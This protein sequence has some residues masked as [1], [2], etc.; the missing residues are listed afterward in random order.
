MTSVFKNGLFSFLVFFVFSLPCAFAGDSPTPQHSPRFLVHLLDYLAK[1]YAGAVSPQ[2]KVLSKSEYAEQVEFVES[3]IST[4]NGLQETK[5]TP[6]IEKDLEQLKTLI[7]GKAQPDDV[8]KLARELQRKVIEVSELEIFPSH[9][10]DLKLGQS[11]YAQNCISCHGER[12]KGDGPA[13]QSLTP[14]PANF[15]DGPRMRE[16]SPFAAFNT[17]R[18]GVSGTAMAGFQGMSD[19]EVWALAFYISSL[20][21]DKKTPEN[22]TEFN[23]N[24]SEIL[25]GAASLSDPALLE[26]LPGSQDEKQKTLAT[27]RTF[28]P[29]EDQVSYL[30]LAR[31]RLNEAKVFFQQ[32][33]IES[34]KTK[35]LQAYLEGIEPIEPKVR[36]TDPS[37]VATIEEKMAAVRGAIESKKTP[38]ELDQAIKNAFGEMEKISK[39]IEHRDMSPLVAFFAAFAII[40]REGFEAVLIILAL[41]GV[42]RAAGAKQAALWVHGG[43]ISAIGCGFIAWM[44]SGWIMGISGASR[45]MM[46]GATSLFAVIVLLYVGFWLHRQ[47]EIGRWKEFLEVKV[48]GFL[49]GR[50]LVGLALISFIAVFREAFETV[51]FLRALWFEGGDSTRMALRFGVFGSL[52]FVIVL[53]WLALNLSKRLPL[54]QLFTLSSVLMLFLATI[55]TGKGLHSIQETGLLGVTSLP[56]RFRW[57]LAGVYPTL[58]TLVSQA[59]VAIL[60]LILW[61]YGRRPS[62]V[63]VKNN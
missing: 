4:N 42:I 39:I 26:L 45:E 22:T 56:F 50:N 58:E 49:H 31:A 63:I 17:I 1:D 2:G 21:F 51:L 41:L 47:S 40:L 36:A 23:S 9:W 25:K 60:V 29:K 61:F 19:E 6:E 5:K 28:S 7:V 54:R 44:F 38:E 16:I 3:A 30:A 8:T 55:L 43:W 20:R 35:A 27:I 48:K 46:E 14:K 24:S 10:P 13:G 57:D 32:G 34:A 37:A 62:V 11:L 33:N 12:G 15:T 52:S 59:V 18:L 53:S